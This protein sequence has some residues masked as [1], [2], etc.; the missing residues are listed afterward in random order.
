MHATG[1]IAS[2]E[3]AT[4]DPRNVHEA[5]TIAVPRL[6]LKGLAAAT[7]GPPPD[8]RLPAPG[9]IA[10]TAMQPHASEPT[11]IDPSAA[12]VS[13]VV[14]PSQ[15]LPHGTNVAEG[16]PAEPLP[17]AIPRLGEN[18][19]ASGHVPMCLGRPSYASSEPTAGVHVPDR[20][21][22]DA[23]NSM[24]PASDGKGNL[25]GLGGP[26]SEALADST[27]SQ[28]DL[29]K[30][31]APLASQRPDATVRPPQLWPDASLPGS[32]AGEAAGL[33]TEELQ[34]GTAEV[35][36]SAANGSLLCATE[37]RA[38]V[39][40]IEAG[41]SCNLQA[42]ENDK[43]MTTPDA[44]VTKEQPGTSS[45][46]DADGSTQTVIPIAGRP[47][48]AACNPETAPIP[49]PVAGVS[50]QDIA[51][52]LLAPTSDTP[53]GMGN[54][55][56]SGAELRPMKACDPATP[57]DTPNCQLPGR[58][59][60]NVCPKVG[61]GLFEASQLAEMQAGATNESAMAI[62]DTDAMDLEV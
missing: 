48:V 38:V 60:A 41:P 11:H 55:P 58:A 26:H 3:V 24:V 23:V 21:L 20:H 37:N 27:S 15:S 13:A 52:S 6:P 49:G 56:G 18:F 14:E 42:G 5:T 39:P 44:L 8:A 31:T 1:A 16:P 57:S 7:P 33:H 10:A 34:S 29:E 12:T 61:G 22:N 17:S 59:K 28:P 19:A 45:N 53:D 40:S 54:L 2:E 47:I 4:L 9:P 25:P 35:A 46:F 50:Q 32:P 36:M 62:A 30:A 51:N 43:N